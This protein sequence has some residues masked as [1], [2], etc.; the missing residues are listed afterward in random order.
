MDSTHLNCDQPQDSQ[1]ELANQCL[2]TIE[3]KIISTNQFECEQVDNASIIN[4]YKSKV[5]DIVNEVSKD[6]C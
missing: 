4:N 3:S 5:Q 1:Q 6:E 2:K